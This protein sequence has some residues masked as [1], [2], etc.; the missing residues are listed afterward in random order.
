MK[1]KQEAEKLMNEML[2]LAKRMLREHGEF[3][4][5]GGYMKPNGEIVHVGVE[6]ASTEHPKS[7][8][9][10]TILQ[11]SFEKL[12]NEQQCKAVAIVCNVVVSVPE[13]NHKSDAIQICLEHVGNYSAEVF[14]PYHIANNEVKFE[15]IF[16][17]QGKRQFF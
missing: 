17:Q 1:S 2:P 9:L 15:K 4:P 13:T 5:Y 11:K 14:F 7:K 10:I 16:A 8:E 3:F 6:D 12:V